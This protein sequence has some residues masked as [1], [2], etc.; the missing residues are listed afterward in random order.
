MEALKGGAVT[1]A[2]AGNLTH[3]IDKIIGVVVELERENER[4]VWRV[5]AP[6]AIGSVA[7]PSDL[8]GKTGRHGWHVCNGRHVCPGCDQMADFGTDRLGAPRGEDPG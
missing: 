1:D 3:A 6:I 2:S 5:R 8:P 7:A 4:L